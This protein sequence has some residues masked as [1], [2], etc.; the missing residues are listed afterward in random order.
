MV[1]KN[2]ISAKRV[3]K[4]I[5]VIIK[6]M[7]TAIGALVM[8]AEAALEIFGYAEVFAFYKNCFWWLIGTITIA[9]IWKNWDR[10]SFTVNIKDSPD[11]N[12]TL[13]VCDALNNQGA[14]IIPTNT[15]FDTKM[16]DEF[17]SKGSIQG[18]YQ[19]KYFKDRISDL[20]NRLEA[21]LSGKNY[22]TLNDKRKSKTKR[23]PI[24]TICRISENGKR[25]YFLADSD[26]NEYGIPI[27][28]DA[29]N[30]SIA[31]VRLWESLAEEGNH[32]PY[33]IP[34]LGTGK[35]RVKDASR[36]EIVKRIV[37]SF[38]A[39]TKSHKVTENL[40]I[41]IHTNDYG[42]VDWDELCEFLRYQSQYANI[43]SLRASVTGKE[44]QTSSVVE[45]RKETIIDDD[46]TDNNILVNKHSLDTG[47]VEKERLVVTLLMG[48]EMNRAD[49][50]AALG[51]SMNATNRILQKLVD[52]GVIQSKGARLNRVYYC[53]VTENKE[54]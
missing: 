47:L 45:L 13:K 15:T 40:T 5:I 1:Y 25:A 38:L 29:N 4:R 12:I 43:K 49:I 6:D 32:E 7:L 18:Q 34:L 9:C 20:D 37:L 51:L 23:Y 21:G 44:D 41:C 36:E 17:I 48:N 31:L 8:I 27:D 28:V 35:A 46:N 42:K 24:G 50:A 19:L 30:I 54:E 53:P 10:L 52:A 33:S 16:D 11:V 26:I 14:I 3:E 2:I 39:A 22:T